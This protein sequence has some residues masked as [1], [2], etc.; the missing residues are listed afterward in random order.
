MNAALQFCIY[1]AFVLGAFYFGGVSTL[2]T[3]AL[4]SMLALITLV[5]VIGHGLAAL[6]GRTKTELRCGEG[7][8]LT[9]LVWIAVLSLS[10]WFSVY[11]PASFTALA[12]FMSYYLLFVLVVNIFDKLTMAAF[13]RIIFILGVALSVYGI[14]VYFMDDTVLFSFEKHVYLNRLTATFINPNH[15]ASF[16]GMVFPL[17]LPLMLS[18][19]GWARAA[20][21]LGSLLMLIAFFLTFSLAG[22]LALI[23]ALLM[24][25]ILYGNF[26]AYPKLSTAHV[27][28]KGFLFLAA[29]SAAV[30]ALM[31]LS[32]ELVRAKFFS[33]WQREG[34]YR[35]IIAMV[36]NGEGA[37]VRDFGRCLFGG[38]VGCFRELFHGAYGNYELSEFLHAH[39]EYIEFFIEA[40]VFGMMLFIVFIVLVITRAINFV[41]S[42]VESA[43]K[44]PVLACSTSIV[45]LAV[46]AWFEF[47]LRI[48]LVGLTF[49]ALA[50]LIMAATA[51]RVSVTIIR[52]GVAKYSLIALAL[53]SMLISVKELVVANL[54]TRA[55]RYVAARDFG[56]MR[57]CFSIAH[58]LSPY[59]ATVNQNF[60]LA[61]LCQATLEPE[62][63]QPLTYEAL[64]QFHRMV[65]KDPYVPEYYCRVGWMLMQAGEREKA[66]EFFNKG[67]EA[68]PRF[69]LS[70][71]ERAHFYFYNDELEKAAKDYN[72]ILDI[73]FAIP[74][75]R[76]SRT[77]LLVREIHTHMMQHQ[78][79]PE[80]QET[81][82]KIAAYW[83]KV[84]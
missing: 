36:F 75:S 9:L 10:V 35:G 6:R 42:S 19:R 64:M 73:A 44:M 18:A 38:G 54:M 59:N 55:E 68:N 39:N 33:I 28:I 41:M 15:I 62:K 24:L 56:R 3:F 65:T 72:M 52:R 45:F 84:E 21:G 27:L 81:Y 51:P 8:G 46:Q 79:R 34:L 29:T 23:V 32:P 78:L 77:A 71:L 70:Y 61:L 5:F 60:G 14:G 2:G 58:G 48:P 67:I 63:A 1:L 69:L 16:L 37:I 20:W 17:S 12:Q 74:E 40:G 76:D 13:I 25:Y 26:I 53:F 66:E 22:Y 47:P 4:N 31:V 50:G 7:A 49:F 43:T 83:E 57:N 30:I 82:D 11:K 80:L